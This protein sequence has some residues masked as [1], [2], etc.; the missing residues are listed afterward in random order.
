MANEEL[1]VLVENTVPKDL[2]GLHM[3]FGVVP[4]LVR[5]HGADL[6]EVMKKA[7]GSAESKSEMNNTPLLT[8]QP[9]ST[10]MHTVFDHGPVIVADL[11]SFSNG[12]EFHSIFPQFMT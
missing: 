7:A 10:P 2:V 5:R 9:K 6:L 12:D 4:P 1:L 8:S 11:W 3:C